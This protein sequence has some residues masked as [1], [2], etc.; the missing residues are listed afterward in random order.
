MQ[1]ASHRVQQRR[2]VAEYARSDPVRPLP[3]RHP[4]PFADEPRSDELPSEARGRARGREGREH[5]RQ[6]ESRQAGVVLRRR[7]SRFGGLR[8]GQPPCLHVSL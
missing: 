3:P 1:H 7:R 2:R 8:L 4:R 5:G 6:L